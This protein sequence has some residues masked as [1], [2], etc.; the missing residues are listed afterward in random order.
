M[1]L[2]KLLRDESGQTLVFAALAMVIL[3]SSLGLA[4]DVGHLRYA[5]RHLQTAADAAALAAGLEIRVCGAQTNCAGMVT[6]AQNALSENGFTGST[7]INNCAGTPVSGLTLTINTPPCALGA[8]D[9]N[10][11][12]KFYVE[13]EVAQQVKMYFARVIG[14]NTVPLVARAEVRRGASPCIYTLSPDD[15]GS[16]VAIGALNAGCGIVDESSDGAAAICAAGIFA[17]PSIK[18][19]G[20]ALGLLCPTI[21]PARTNVARPTPADPLA[22]LQP[23]F[24]PLSS[25]PCGKTSL[26]TSQTHGSSGLMTITLLNGP[27]TLYSDKAYCGGVVI[28]VGANVTFVE[29]NG[30][31]FVL[32]SSNLLGLPISTGG[33]AISLLSSVQGSGVTFDNYGPVGGFTLAGTLPLLTSVNL[34]APKTGV[35][36]GILFYQDPQNVSPAL[37]AA[38]ITGSLLPGVTLTPLLTSVTMEGG[39]YLPK[40]SLVYGVGT[41]GSY[42]VLV[43]R[44]IIFA[45]TLTLNN[46]TSTLENGSPINSDDIQLVQ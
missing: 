41:P 33:L 39:W 11:G 26:A 35:F 10:T 13:V 29:S 40:A 8:K 3:I 14:F 43:A 27:V 7:V 23:Y 36:S 12:R 25:V 37:A 31:P 46:D 45:A 17:A 42:T 24:N 6:A 16:L 4:I 32:K 21:P 30:Q 34:T 22:Y 18:I 2:R 28:T 9:P 44:D 38:T 15:T 19:T 5:R 20:G 1:T